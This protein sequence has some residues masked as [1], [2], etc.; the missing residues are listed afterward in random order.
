[1]IRLELPIPET[2]TVLFLIAWVAVLAPKFW[3]GWYNRRCQAMWQNRF[4]G[5]VERH[6]QAVAQ[7]FAILE[8]RLENKENLNRRRVGRIWDL[9]DQVTHLRGMVA[10]LV[11]ADP[12]VAY[13]ALHGS[14]T[15]DDLRAIFG[16]S[17]AVRVADLLHQEVIAR[18]G[19]E[20]FV[21][22][23]DP[24]RLDDLM[25]TMETPL[26]RHAEVVHTSTPE[27]TI[28]L[29]AVRA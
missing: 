18:D 24:G 22:R 19:Q 23:P 5:A 13:L 8:R 3:A 27:A 25:I 17:T 4:Q 20:A 2:I 29:A 6:K 26:V 10:F 11:R 15:L 21:F 9:E 14:T 12:I 7:D 16:G 1:M 28:R